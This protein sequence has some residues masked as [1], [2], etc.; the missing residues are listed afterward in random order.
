MSEK[1]RDPTAQE[2]QSMKRAICRTQRP[3]GATPIEGDLRLHGPG[4]DIQAYHGSEW[5]PYRFQLGV[6]FLSGTE[7]RQ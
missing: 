2:V 1:W 7:V 3:P 4:E 5:V 6:P